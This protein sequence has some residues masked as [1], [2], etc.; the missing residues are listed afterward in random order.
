MII[1]IIL[2]KNLGWNLRLTLKKPNKIAL[3]KIAALLFIGC[4]FSVDLLYAF[5][6][7]ER[8]PI[9][10]SVD[11]DGN[12]TYRE[13][14]L[15]EIIASENPSFI[16]KIFKRFD[17][18]YYDEREIRRDQV[19]L[20]RYYERRG[21]FQV[22]VNYE[23]SEDD[24]SW[25][26]KI[27]FNISEG[28]PLTIA[29]L[30]VIIEA[31]SAKTHELRDT[32]AFQRALSR[33]EYQEGRRYEPIRQADVEGLFSE[34]LG[35]QGYAW[36]QVEIQTTV[37]SLAS[38]VA[39]EIHLTPNSKTYYSEFQIEGEL[40][41]P[42]RILL[43]QSGLDN[44]EMYTRADIKDA[45][46]NIFNHHLFRFATITLPE[47]PHDSTLTALI[48]IREYEP[49][50]VR[51]SIGVGMEEII[52]GQVQWEHRNINGLG[53]K[54]SASGRASFI[55][56]R[57]ATDYLVP[58]IFN[59]KSRNVSSIFGLHRIEESFE[60]FQVGLNNSLI[61]QAAQN[62][63]ASLSYE[64]SLN[65]ELS[66]DEQVALPDTVRAYNISS[67]ILSGYYNE[68]LISGR[69]G[70]FLQPALELSGMFGEAS[71]KFQKLNVDVRKYTPITNSL[72]LA[73]RI[74]GGV[75]FY[76]QPDSLPSNIRFFSGGTN[77]VRGW[78]RHRLGP[79]IAAFDQDG[80]FDS[81]IPI[82]GRTT[83]LFNVEL[84]QS[85]ERFI[86][87]IGIA[88]FLDGGQV[89]SDI[90]SLQERNI[91]FGAGGGIR[92]QSPIGPVR[93]DIAYK[94]NPTD[95]D[96]QI[97]NGEDYGSAWD[98]IGIH[99]SIGQAF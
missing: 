82:G 2:Q 84:R 38:E 44:G 74:S 88:A 96:L 79:K 43:R 13:V 54:F 19:R 89:W 35:N 76:T 1:I 32:R 45:Q 80:N 26:K 20:Q 25:Q 71:F 34:A 65:E 50:T 30:D 47:Q 85:L 53:H 63:T 5:Q 48:R 83:F 9:V 97:Y 46:R 14:V 59:A 67:F 23:V 16:K 36:P 37:D 22:E 24:E 33:H 12:E 57:V 42:Q 73:N 31:D 64:Y 92:Y 75:T 28:V 58:Y 69:R 18:Y 15:K 11:M 49:R 93:V 90:E 6:D 21:F 91:Q 62:K 52:R 78:N 56:Q 55:E 27:R 60:L 61:Y 41:V 39:V 68:G 86:P 72:T 17:G 94:L 40:S 99:F 95:E 98:R 7:E 3:G 10:W 87:N 8:E 81:Y 4:F 77:T 70:W 51:A 66:S 29:S